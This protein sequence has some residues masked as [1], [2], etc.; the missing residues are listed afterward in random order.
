MTKILLGVSQSTLSS[1]IER[2]LHPVNSELDQGLSS[3]IFAFCIQYYALDARNPTEE[4]KTLLKQI[5]SAGTKAY[6]Y[7][8]AGYTMGVQQPKSAMTKKELL[9]DIKLDT[10]IEAERVK[11]AALKDKA[12]ASSLKLQALK[13]KLA[14]QSK[15]LHARTT[16]LLSQGAKV[17]GDMTASKLDLPVNTITNLLKAHGSKLKPSEANNALVNLGYLEPTKDK[18]TLEG[19]YYGR[20]VISS[21]STHTTLARWFPAEFENLLGQINQYYLDKEQGLD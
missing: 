14:E 10:K 2:N 16:K 5:T 20:T 3:E 9:E 21:K 15:V 11:Q 19:N 17:K 7:H 8:L 13:D 18:V 12:K 6:L 1:Y 4:A